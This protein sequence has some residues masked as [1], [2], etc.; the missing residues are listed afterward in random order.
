MPRRE[1][2]AVCLFSLGKLRENLST[3][4]VVV[5]EEEEEEVGEEEEEQPVV[6]LGEER[7]AERLPEGARERARSR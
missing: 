7:A 5:G 6:V 1:R 2:G 3:G 4:A